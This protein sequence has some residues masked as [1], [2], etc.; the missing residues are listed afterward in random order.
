MLFFCAVMPAFIIRAPFDQTWSAELNPNLSRLQPYPFQKLAALLAGITPD[1]A[2]RP[3]SL[4]IGE[5]KHPTP[6]F[7]RDALIQQLGGLSSYPATTGS[8]ALR[9]AIARWI[10]RRYRI[11]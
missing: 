10:E 8:E 1:P 3:I 4:S 11:E 7:I 6:Q 2:L 9:N 5:P